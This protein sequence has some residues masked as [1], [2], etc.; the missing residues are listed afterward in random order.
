ML[1]KTIILDGFSKTYAMT[2]WRLGYGVMPEWLVAAVN[3]LM[4]N[5]NSCAASFTQRA[6]IDALNGSQSGVEQMIEEFRRRRSAFCSALNEIFGFSCRPPAGAFYAFA[7]VKGTG[8]PS[9]E[10]ADLLLEQAGVACL[11]G[12]SFGSH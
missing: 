4:V 6:A 2:G 9:R 7:N 10:L 11:N 12:G 5:S 1:E 3:D 8:M